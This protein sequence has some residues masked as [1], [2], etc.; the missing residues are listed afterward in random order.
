MD[1]LQLI[2]LISHI[3]T[4]IIA[5]AGIVMA[6]FWGYKPPKN[7]EK[8]QQLQKELLGCYRDISGLLEIEKEYMAKEDISKKKTRL[9]KSFSKNIE[10]KRVQNRIK[11]L[12]SLSNK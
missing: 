9:G 8:I 4:V 3:A 7:A 11:E 12:E 5:V 10:P 2:Q 6:Y 1:N